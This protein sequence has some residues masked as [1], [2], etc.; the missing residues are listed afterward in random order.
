MIAGFDRPSAGR[1]L[2]DGVDIT[3]VPPNQRDLNTM[4]QNYALFPNYQV[5]DNA[6]YGL[7]VRKTPAA[8]THERVI[9]S[10]RRFS[11]RVDA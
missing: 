1:I 8:E 2:L 7:K 4:F 5:F 11:V 6:A 3:A 10:R 9:S